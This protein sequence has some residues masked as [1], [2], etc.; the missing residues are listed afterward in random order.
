MNIKK[1][2]QVRTGIMVGEMT[3]YGS[4][5][6]SWTKKQKAALDKHNVKY[7]YVDCAT[8]KCPE[9]VK[10]FPTIL[11]SGYADIFGDDQAVAGDKAMMA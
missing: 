11:W 7:D 4:D 3:L 1:S 9:F 8:G 10:G 6:C 5:N 2:C